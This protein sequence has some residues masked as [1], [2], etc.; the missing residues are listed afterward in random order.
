MTDWPT[1]RDE[2]FDGGAVAPL[3]DI[4]SMYWF[5][6]V[7]RPDDTVARLQRMARD[8]PN[9]ARASIGD[10]GMDGLRCRPDSQAVARQLG[11]A[12]TRAAR[13]CGPATRS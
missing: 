3:S 9:V 10:T 2:F 4:D 1:G 11:V 5:M 8:L 12:D 7:R 6:A 13:V